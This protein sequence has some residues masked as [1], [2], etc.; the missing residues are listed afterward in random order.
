MPFYDLICDA[1]GKE[2][3]IMAKIS[4]REQKLIK[5]P[6]CGN[7]ELKP[8]FKSLNFMISRKQDKP[9]CPNIERC[10]SCCNFRE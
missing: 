10:G 3:N 1:C 5:C 4:E 9:V 2:F 6:Y 7:N 8:V